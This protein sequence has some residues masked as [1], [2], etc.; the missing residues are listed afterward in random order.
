MISSHC[1]RSVSLLLTVDLNFGA[2]VVDGVR[3][4]ALLDKCVA[5]LLAQ[6]H[7]FDAFALE[8]GLRLVEAEVDEEFV[9]DGLTDTRRG[10]SARSASQ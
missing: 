8:S 4:N 3:V 10:R 2:G 7:A 5:V 9:L 6:I 1:L